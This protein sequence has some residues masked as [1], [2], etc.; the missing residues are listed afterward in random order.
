MAL[1]SPELING[2][3]KR[4]VKEGA[5]SRRHEPRQRLRA[6]RRRPFLGP[7]RKTALVAW[8]CDQSNLDTC[9]VDRARAHGDR[10][11]TARVVRGPKFHRRGAAAPHRPFR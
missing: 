5:T 3:R 2:C 6:T 7:N 9:A 10:L 11:A 8:W 4:S 1:A